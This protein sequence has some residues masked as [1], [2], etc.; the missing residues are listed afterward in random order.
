MKRPPFKFYPDDWQGNTK[1]RRCS[2]SDKGIWLDVLCLMHDCEEYGILRWP[3]K[4]IAQAVG[5][6]VAA[7]RSLVTKGVL[8]GSDAGELIDEFV[9]VPRSG[10][11]DGEPVTLITP[12]RGPLW[13][14]SRMVR[15]EYIR[16]IRGE[17]SRF[18]AP[19]GVAPKPTSLGSA[20]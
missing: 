3:L 18:S 19:N 5:C 15:D 8:K 1:L 13:Y 20:G 6:S 9:Y 14:S 16:T 10:R 12:Q 17:S 4:E 7:L 11:K 2:H